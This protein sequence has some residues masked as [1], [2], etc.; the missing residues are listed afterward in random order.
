MP[1]LPHAHKLHNMWGLQLFKAQESFAIPDLL[2]G[3]HSAAVAPAA[4]AERLE[5]ASGTQ[6][7]SPQGAE[8]DASIRHIY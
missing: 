5:P 6:N 4:H 8:M 3:L 7:S 1:G 2:S